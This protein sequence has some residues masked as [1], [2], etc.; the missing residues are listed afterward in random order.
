MYE[1]SSEQRKELLAY[2]SRRPYV[3]VASLIAMLASL[4]N[5][6]NNA[7]PKK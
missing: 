4:K 7:T 2:L 1:L 5:K 6:N 3:E